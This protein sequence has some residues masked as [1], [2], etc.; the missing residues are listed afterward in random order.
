MVYRTETKCVA[1]NYYQL[2]E[3][4]LFFEKLFMLFYVCFST[5]IC[6]NKISNNSMP[7]MKK[8][9]KLFSVL[10]CKINECYEYS[11]F[12]AQSSNGKHQ[13]KN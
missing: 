6:V 7:L 10:H 12:I 4:N 11:C 1:Y 13:H 9:S 8:W 2:K 5:A 3:I